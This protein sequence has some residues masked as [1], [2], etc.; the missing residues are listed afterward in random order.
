LA[1]SSLLESV[2]HSDTEP[3]VPLP[4]PPPQSHNLRIFKGAQ[5]QKRLANVIGNAV[6]ARDS[7]V[8]A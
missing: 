7:D 6:H 2:P 8:Q 5:G 1:I 4:S 3:M